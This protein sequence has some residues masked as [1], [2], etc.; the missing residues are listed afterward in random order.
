MIVG[1]DGI[2]GYGSI[3]GNGGGVGVIIGGNGG[4]G[5]VVV[6]ITGNV[7]ISFRHPNHPSLCQFSAL[8]DFDFDETFLMPGKLFFGGEVARLKRRK[9]KEGR[10]EQDTKYIKGG[11]AGVAP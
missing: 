1:N 8:I 6:V 11:L 9:R 10:K 5:V 7:D 2:V 4:N 3:G